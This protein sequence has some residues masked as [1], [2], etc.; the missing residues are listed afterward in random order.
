MVDRKTKY[1]G[2]SNRSSLGRGGIVI[3]PFL[4]MNGN[5]RY[6][7]G[8]SK[9]V[10]LKIRING[11]R[12]EYNKRDSVIRIFDLE[13][14]NSYF[15]E[16]DQFSFDNIAWQMKLKNMSVVVDPNQFKLV[17]I[18][19][20]V[21]GEGSGMV[22]FSGAGGEK[23]LGRIIVNYYKSNG[24]FFAKTLTEPDGYYSFLGLPPGSYIARI[25]TAQMQKL[26]MT[27]TPAVIP[28]TIRG[29]AEGDVKD[30]LDFVIKSNRVEEVKREDIKPEEVKKTE[31]PDKPE[32]IKKTEDLKKTE[33]IKK[34]EDLRKMEDLKKTEA[35]Q[36]KDS[37]SVEKPKKEATVIQPAR[38]D[39][40][41]KEQ[42]E[43]KE[44]AVPAK[45]SEPITVKPSEPIAA[46]PS[47]QI[48]AGQTG[49]VYC[50]QI[51]ASKTFI[52]PA[53][54]KNKFKLTDEV[55]YF[56]KDGWFKYVTGQ[57]ATSKEATAKMTQLGINGFVTRVDKAGLKIK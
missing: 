44:A 13:S 16:L 20:S 10:G 11:G 26:N 54:Y 2:V 6:E 9:V 37:V 51:A 49:M 55:L 32:I 50:I 34:T 39:S 14:Y 56:Q 28:F 19:I 18:P 23:G 1:V 24:A 40:V 43:K 5:G 46:K 38:K 29:G 21:M 31:N 8:E 17:E 41:V 47:E 3:L 36:K 25:D 30:G 12:V 4:D 35:V 27:A 57:F 48:A 45:P 7:K 33:D 22:T 15:I 42:P 53:D 52:D